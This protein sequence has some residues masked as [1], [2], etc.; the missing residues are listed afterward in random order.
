MVEQLFSV[1]EQKAGLR[2]R[3]MRPEP[4]YAPALKS[5]QISDNLPFGRLFLMSYPTPRIALSVHCI[6]SF[7][8][9]SVFLYHLTQMHNNLM[10]EHAG[11]IFWEKMDLGNIFRKNHDEDD[12]GDA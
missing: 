11:K 7:V 6:G 9:S 5:S 10:S 2:D 1:E 8:R 12:E 4:K 3:D